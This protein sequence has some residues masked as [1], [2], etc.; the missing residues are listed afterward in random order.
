VGNKFYLASAVTKIGREESGVD[1]A[2]GWIS[3]PARMATISRNQADIVYKDGCYCIEN[4]SRT[5]C[6]QI[7]GVP[8]P[9]DQSIKVKNLDVIS[10][11]GVELTYMGPK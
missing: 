4:R 6:T 10:F 8:L 3:F 1:K 5:N 7:N 9:L 2:Y 11:G